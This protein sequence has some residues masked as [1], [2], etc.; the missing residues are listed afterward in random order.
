M[1]RAD[2]FYGYSFI[3]RTIIF[4]VIP[5]FAVVEFVRLKRALHIFQL[6][7]YKRARFLDW[8]RGDRRRA[9]FLKKSTTKKPLVMTARARRILIAATGA[10]VALLYIVPGLVH[11]SVGAP[12]DLV[13]WGVLIVLA[14]L[15]VPHALVA[16]DVAL[17]PLQA[18]INKRFM[19]SA[20]AKLDAINPVVIGI[21]GSF[22]KTSTKHAIGHLLGPPDLVVITPGSYN[23]PMG[24]CRTINEQLQPSHR[25]LVVEMGAFKEGDV[26]ELTSFVRPKVGVLTAI[27]PAHLERFGSMDA[28]RQ[29]KYEI[30]TGLSADGVA[31]MNVDDDDV[32]SLAESTTN[33][34]VVRYGL[35]PERR[36]DVMAT[37]VTVT[38]QGTEFMIVDKARG[39]SLG[40]GMKLL[41]RHAVGHVL[42]AVAVAQALGKSLR[43]LS[44][45]IASLVPVEHRLQIIEG[46]GGVTVIDDAYNS[47]PAGASAAL[48]VL[49]RMPG[50]KKVVVTPGIV[51]LGP[52]QFDAN[53]RFGRE[54]AAVADVL[55][56]VAAVNREAMAK[57]AGD[58]GAEVI[59]VD[60]LAEATARLAS[61]LGPGDVVLFENDLPD[62]YE[63]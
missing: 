20:R 44:E 40:V 42:A 26:A 15:A 9:L 39:E 6:E 19:R 8:C 43:E 62:H 63:G 2:P 21:T 12:F 5:A 11:I 49:A 47:N 45:A 50:H 30:V 61:I 37:N 24:V 55:I 36:P 14:F 56:V 34:R 31:V 16:A 1:D 52:L 29:A 48:D 51:E 25:F 23:T 59:I 32:N 18:A 13:A 17:S 58:R 46:A 38:E 41:G 54:A 7:G 22:G 57:G 33:V 35:N 28:I 10:V 60:T 27:G 3:L 53:E 4:V